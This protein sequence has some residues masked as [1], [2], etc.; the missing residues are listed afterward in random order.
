MTLIFR[1]Y[2]AIFWPILS[3][4]PKTLFTILILS[5][6]N[7]WE[8]CFI[9]ILGIFIC[10]TN[11]EK[12]LH[13]YYF[14]PMGPTSFVSLQW[15]GT[16]KCWESPR[17]CTR[18]AIVHWSMLSGLIFRFEGP[19]YCIYHSSVQTVRGRS[20]VALRNPSMPSIKCHRHQLYSNSFISSS[21]ILCFPSLTLLY[22]H[23][24]KSEIRKYGN[25]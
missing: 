5:R 18:I 15:F 21:S 25:A 2:N 19:S 16:E 1:F 22:L 12:S 20:Y 11:V 8:R 23:I 6:S 24:W 10:E 17:G 9:F 13:S 7:F 14:L 4:D 3:L